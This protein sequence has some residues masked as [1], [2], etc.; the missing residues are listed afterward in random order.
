MAVKR[1]VDV[2][3]WD[4]YR[5]LDEL[6][7]EDR[8]FYL[9]LLTN[10]NST[11]AGIY[12]LPLRTIAHKTGFG[13]EVVYTLLERFE[14]SLGLI[15]YN[16][17]TQEITVLE[18]LRYSIVK[19]GPHVLSLI[20]KELNRIKDTQLIVA[21]LKYNQQY[22]NVSTKVF[23]RTLK[24]LL[25]KEIKRRQKFEEA[26][27]NFENTFVLEEGQNYE[28]Q[29]FELA[30][31]HSLPT[32]NITGFDGDKTLGSKD[33]KE[34]REAGRGAANPAKREV[35][36]FSLQLFEPQSR[37]QDENENVNEDDNVNDN[38]NE[39]DNEKRKTIIPFTHS[40]F[41]T[42]NKS[43]LKDTGAVEVDLEN[44]ELLP[45]KHYC[46]E[47]NLTFTESQLQSY[48]EWLEK[49]SVELLIESLRRSLGKENIF[50]YSM[51]ILWNWHENGVTSMAGVEQSESKP[52]RNK[53]IRS[54]ELAVCE[55]LDKAE[56]YVAEEVDEEELKRREAAL[57]QKLKDL[58]EP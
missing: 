44:D 40:L 20:E 3:F 16:F 47:R 52:K 39:D 34:I 43:L 33:L 23:Y 11:Q 2:Y 12:Q 27:Q 25:I 58:L 28:S 13:R 18:S 24:E 42:S 26:A 36:P 4:D 8:Y 6:S 9:F 37:Q 17:Q 10:P 30:E 5:I 38:V 32:R 35:E 29:N 7:I 21:T 14:K 55:K 56:E 31:S 22:F 15:K 19:G 45:F 51:K 41:M 57:R 54:H 46:Q 48:R 50:T 49:L 1:V 53:A